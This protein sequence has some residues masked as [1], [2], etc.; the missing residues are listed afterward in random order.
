MID[1]ESEVFSRVKAAVTKEIPGV[2]MVSEYATMHKS[3]PAT[4]RFLEEHFAP[5]IKDNALQTLAEL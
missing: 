2:N 3:K 5:I 1:I 4:E